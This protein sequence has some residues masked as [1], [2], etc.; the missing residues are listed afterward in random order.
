MI[1]RRISNSGKPE[2]PVPSVQWLK[3]ILRSDF[4]QAFACRIAALYIRLVHVTGRWRIIGEDIP[5]SFRQAGKP[6][7]MTFWHGRLMMMPYAWR[8]TN[9]VNMLASAHRDGRLIGITMARFGVVPVTGS[10]SKGGAQATRMLIRLLRR[11]GVAGITPDGPRGP[12]MR[13]GEG[14]ITLARL[15]GAPILPVAFAATR[16]RVMGSWDRFIVALPFARGIFLWGDPVLVP[17]DV[18]DAGIEMYRQKVEQALNNL[19]RRAD[20]M[21]GQPV[22][23]PA[24]LGDSKAKR[25]AAR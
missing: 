2:R 7:I 17:R 5:E 10:A 16:Q 1:R 14:T 8:G 18:D 25:G 15:S 12:R 19:A 23:E 6:L 11:G 4:A 13:V 20:A 22:I 24:A 21:A 3:R 9:Q